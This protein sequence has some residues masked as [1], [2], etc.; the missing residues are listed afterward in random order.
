MCRIPALQVQN[1]CRSNVLKTLILLVE[2]S[3]LLRVASER[4]LVKA[5][6][7]VIAATDGEEAL[8]MSREHLPNLILLDMMLP[9][10][11]GI[12]VLRA[13]K[14]DPQ[15]TDIPVIVLTGL[16]QQNSVKLIKEGATA[17]F[18]KSDAL[19]D[20][21]SDTLLQVVETVLGQ[22]QPDEEPSLSPVC[23][24]AP[25][26]DIASRSIESGGTIPNDGNLT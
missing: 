5:G 1:G 10:L 11:D 13:L 14:R 16:G 23:E 12:E 7:S 24:L 8:S 9:K 4:V 25:T 18:M 26:I 19:L 3:R 17:Y 22:R 21:N 20:S 6:Y 2:E 15:T